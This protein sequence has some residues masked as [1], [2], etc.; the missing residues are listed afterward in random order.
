MYWSERTY[1][2]ERCGIQDKETRLHF[3][4]EIISN[5][6]LCKT[7]RRALLHVLAEIDFD[8]YIPDTDALCTLFGRYNTYQPKGD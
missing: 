3:C 5:K 4:N 6:A 8:K 1:Y 7:I 2:N